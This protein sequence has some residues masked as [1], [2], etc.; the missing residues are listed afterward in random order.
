MVFDNILELCKKRGITIAKL[1]RETGIGNGTISR[2]NSSSH[3]VKNLKAVADYFGVT[4]DS[5]LS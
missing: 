3:S 2:W 4:M 1:E 5:L